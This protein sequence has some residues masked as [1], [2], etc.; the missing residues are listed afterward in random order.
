MVFLIESVATTTLLSALVYLCHFVRAGACRVVRGSG[1]R[2][3]DGALE[4]AADGHLCHCLDT[5]FLVAMD[6]VDADIVLS[7]AGRSER[8]HCGGGGGGCGGGDGD[9]VNF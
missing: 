7:V 4:Q 1:L 8:R 2:C 3:L 6:L 5:G 9:G